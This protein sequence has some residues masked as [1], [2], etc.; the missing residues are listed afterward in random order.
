M[1]RHIFFIFFSLMTLLPPARGGKTY[2]AYTVRARDAYSSVLRLRLDEASGRLDRLKLVEPD[3][4]IVYHIEDYVD[5]FRLFITEDKAL[6]KRLEANKK[7]RLRH[8]RSGDPNSPYYLYAQAEINLHWALLRI[9]AGQYLSAFNEVSEAYRLLKENERK[10]PGFMGN[11]KSLGILHA[12]VGAVPDKYRWGVK[13][14]GNMDGSIRQGRREIEEVLAYAQIHRDFIFKE[15]TEILYAFMLL[16]LTNQKDQAWQVISGSTLD[17][18][19]NPLACFVQANIALHA[20]RSAE[21]ERILNLAPHGDGFFELPYLYFMKGLTK[22]YRLD[23]RAEADFKTFLRLQHGQSYVKEAYQKLAWNALVHG[24]LAGYHTYMARC[25]TE[26]TR[27][28]EGDDAA[29]KDA[30]SGQTPDI[31]LLQAR[32][33]FDGGY[34]KRAHGLLAQFKQSDFPQEYQ[35]EFLYRSARLSQKLGHDTE[36]ILRYLDVLHF[37]DK[38]GSYY[39]CNAALQIG[40]IYEKNGNKAQ[41]RRFF[42]RVLKMNPRQYKTS[43]HA[44]AKAGLNRLG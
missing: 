16:Y 38:T 23:A 27:D 40:L 13:L 7:R 4:M 29:Y 19:D 43:L 24:D 18:A 21:A 28:Q 14:I 17:P 15:E 42:K 39:P 34:Y 2:F 8:I 33:L 20:G 30:I 3:N 36:A 12:V 9:K 37:Q 32:M 11:K 31:R 26:G 6:F 44:K 41:A 10:F 35:L 5:F 25:K 1:G 22:L